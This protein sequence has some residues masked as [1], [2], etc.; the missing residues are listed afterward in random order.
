MGRVYLV[1]DDGEIARRRRERPGLIEAWPDLYLGDLFWLGDDE[2]RRVAYSAERREPAPGALYWVGEASKVA[3]D[4]AGPPLAWDLA[5]EETSVPI[6]YGPGLTET[7]SLPAEDSVRARVLSAHG[8]AAIWTTYDASGTRVE[9]R[10]TSPLDPIFPLR[11]PGGK[12]VHLFLALTT[13]A[14]AIGVMAG[15]PSPEPGASAWAEK[16]PAEDFA[17]LIRRHAARP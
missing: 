1:S 5:I 13:K 2:A 14:E 3:L 9:H 6:Y 12:T 17:D 4:R 10:P 11:R 8:I 7:E 15:G 16:L